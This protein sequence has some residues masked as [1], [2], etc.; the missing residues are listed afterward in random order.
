MWHTSL[1]SRSRILTIEQ[2]TYF[3]SIAVKVACSICNLQVILNT[4]TLGF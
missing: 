1:N 3:G 2:K 4:R